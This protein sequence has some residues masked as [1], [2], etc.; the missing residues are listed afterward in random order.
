MQGEWN[1]RRCCSFLFQNLG[2]K[3][4]TGLRSVSFATPGVLPKGREL[5]WSF[6]LED[7]A[8]DLVVGALIIGVSL[9]DPIVFPEG[10]SG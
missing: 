2:P 8:L 5:P 7:R 10:G 4:A 6:E 9:L 3:F 1:I